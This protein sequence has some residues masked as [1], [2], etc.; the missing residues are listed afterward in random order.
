MLRCG[1]EAFCPQRA[2]PASPAP[3]LTGGQPQDTPGHPSLRPYRR[4]F[5]ADPRLSPK[6]GHS[7]RQT[8]LFRTRTCVQ[9]AFSTLRSPPD[10]LIFFTLFRAP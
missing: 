9:R 7:G 1:D 2:L 4:A 5:S 3:R 6:S 10:P 8:L